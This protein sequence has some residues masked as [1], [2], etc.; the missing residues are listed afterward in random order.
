MIMSA[1]DAR[2]PEDHDALQRLQRL[3]HH[4]DMFAAI[5]ALLKRPPPQ[6]G[7][8][9]RGRGGEEVEGRI[10]EAPCRGLDGGDQRRRDALAALPGRHEYA[11]EPRISR[12][13]L[14]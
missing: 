8:E 3:V 6:A 10:A 2:G 9:P 14:E 13:T 12:I 1:Q 4:L 7:I 11:G 5:L